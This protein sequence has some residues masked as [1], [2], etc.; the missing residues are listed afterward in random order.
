M[1]LMNLRSRPSIIL[2]QLASSAKHDFPAQICLA[3]GRVS[4]IHFP[5]N[6]PAFLPGHLFIWPLFSDMSFLWK[7]ETLRT[8]IKCFTRCIKIKIQV[9][10][11]FPGLLLSMADWEWTELGF[12][13]WL[14][15]HTLTL[16]LSFLPY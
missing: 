5:P 4:L 10:Q 15:P 12:V 6:A 8:V 13:N 1:T 16:Y 3:E 9:N 11:S 14:F 2:F 7:P